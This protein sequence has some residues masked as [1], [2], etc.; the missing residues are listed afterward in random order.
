[1]SQR[2]RSS[3]ERPP[4]PVEASAGADDAHPPSAVRVIPRDLV[5]AALAA[6][7]RSADEPMEAERATVLR[8]QH[9]EDVIDVVDPLRA[10]RPVIIELDDLADQRQRQRAMDFV[11]GVA[12]GLE[13]TVSGIATNKRAFLLEP[14]DAAHGRQHQRSV[15]APDTPCDETEPPRR[16]RPAA[17]PL[18]VLCDMRAAEDQFASPLDTVIKRDGSRI[19]SPPAPVCS[20]CRNTIRHWRF[21]LGWCPECERWGRRGVMSACGTRYGH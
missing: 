5:P 12:Y 15:P 17:A 3:S 21:V 1:V 2:H 10:L 16:D 20:H 19:W 13:T 8:P 11:S 9:F 7:G 14:R 4:S 18:C 6:A